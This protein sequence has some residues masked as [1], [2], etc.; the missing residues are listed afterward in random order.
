MSFAEKVFRLSEN[1]T[2]VRQEVMAGIT[3]FVT[4]AYVIFVVPSMVSETGMPRD[5]LFAATIWATALST[6]FM[7]LW[8][9]MP[10]GLAPGMGII[11]YFTYS[12][13]LGMSLPW[14][15]ALGAVF[16]S[17]AVFLFLSVTRIRSLIISSVPKNLTMAI[18][19]GIGLFIAFI[20]LRS[21]GIV[22][23]D[24]AN[25]VALGDLSSTPVLLSLFSLVFTGVLLS[26]HVRG[27][28]L[29][30]ILVTTGIGMIAGA[31]PVP[32]SVSDVVNFN[33]PSIM[34]TFMQLDV[35]AAIKHGL[36]S[37]LFTMTMV[38]L[39]DSIGTIIGVSHKAGLMNWDGSIRGLE[40][41]LVVDSC[42]TIWG[43]FLGTPAV[44]S[45]VESSAGVAEGGRTGLTAVTVGVLFIVC[46]VFAPI[47]GVVQS[48]ATAPALIIVGALMAED[49][50]SIDFKDMTEGLPA[51]LT[52]ISM[53]LTYSIANGFGIGFISYVL[54]KTFTG[55]FREVSPVM[56]IVSVCFAI[57]FVMR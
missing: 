29:I 39:F 3:T 57:S 2:S 22:V 15:T 18:S 6:L 55:R 27:A 4:M 50:P 45:Y 46:L 48:Y 10:I 36:I 5:A 52:I 49:M 7:G 11:A 26:L 14:Q 42:G 20:G 34:P 1:K 30:G 28:I 23:S 16:I 25:S 32:R 56:L 47:V 51:F 13:V 8:A 43:S 53:P 17:G 21:A 12:V 41:A 19:V 31:G 35:M 40:K 24:P 37:V 9:N 33:V 38:D 44:T 54:L